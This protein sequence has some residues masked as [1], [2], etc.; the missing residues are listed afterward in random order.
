MRIGTPPSET[1]A[2]LAELELCGRVARSP[3]GLYRI[4]L[5]HP[6]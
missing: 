3:G 6:P 1:L 5:A 4:P 2:E